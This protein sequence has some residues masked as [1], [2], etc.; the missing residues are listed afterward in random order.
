MPGSQVVRIIALR[1]V[2]RCRTKVVE[3]AS[4]AG[5]MIVVIARGRFGAVF[6]ASPGRPIAVVELRQCTVGV[7]IVASGV[8][9]AGNVVE[10]LCR[11]LILGSTTIGDVARP[12]EDRV[13]RLCQCP[14]RQWERTSQ[15]QPTDHN[16]EKESFYHWCYL[17]LSCLSSKSNR[18]SSV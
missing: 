9:G 6:V 2:A 4:R 8:Y 16:R 18:F 17:I 3:I 10:Q 13:A 14:L 15:H 11:G 5:H 1:P 7:S 12:N